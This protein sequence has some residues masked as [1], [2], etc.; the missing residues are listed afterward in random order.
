M[1][2][3]ALSQ[4]I[5]DEINRQLMEWYEERRREIYGIP[6]SVEKQTPGDDGHL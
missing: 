5:E 3:E 1:D 6:S 2:Y 4:A